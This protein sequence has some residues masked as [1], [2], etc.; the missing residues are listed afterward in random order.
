MMDAEVIAAARAKM[1]AKSKGA[2]TIGGGTRV[3]QKKVHKPTAAD[4]K[5]ILAA[6]KRVGCNPIPGIEEV[7][8]FRE[9][10]KVLHF[11][12][13]K[14]QASIGANTYAISGSGEEKALTELLPGI[15]TQ[16]GPDNMAALKQLAESIQRNEKADDD[17]PDL[18]GENFEDVSKE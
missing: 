4:D 3:K 10:G 1:M 14:L 18:E 11:K 15:L 7:N 2:M 13:P 6:L 16:L 9:D 12:S 5:K 8:M 17:V